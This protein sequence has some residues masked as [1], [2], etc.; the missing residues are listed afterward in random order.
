[1]DGHI[2]TVKAFS[3]PNVITISVD[4]REDIRVTEDHSIEI[5]PQVNVFPG[6][7]PREAS[8]RLA[9]EAPLSVRIGRIEKER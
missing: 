3:H 7:G 5:L 8:N 6:V 2:V 1:V 9:F 4:D